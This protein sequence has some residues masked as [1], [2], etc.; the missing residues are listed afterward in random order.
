[1]NKFY[2]SA[3]SLFLII[4]CSDSVK[5]PNSVELNTWEDSVSYSLGADLGNTFKI[6]EIKYKEDSFN[7]GFIETITRDSSYAYGAS[8]AAN[9]I[10]RDVKINPDILLNALSTYESEDSLKLTNVDIGKTLKKF[11]D[12]MREKIEEQRLKAMEK[13]VVVGD[14]YIEQYKKD[15]K[16]EIETDSGLIYRI[17]KEGYGDIPATDDNVIVHYTG[18]LID[19]TVFDSSINTGEPATFS[20]RGVIKG[21]QEALTLMPVGSKWELVIP[22]I[23][24]YGEK[25][26]GNIPGM[27][28]LIFEVELLG[29]E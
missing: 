4:S 24:G 20:V 1:M 9:F 14:S 2:I 6:R 17:L 3:L 19:G 16:D 25:R 5:V 21:W 13:A 10:I 15:H 12:K 28:T 29:I 8:V 27:S 11:D 7:K 18:K 22:S 26:Q 23:L